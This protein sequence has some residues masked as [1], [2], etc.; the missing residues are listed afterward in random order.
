MMGDGF[1]ADYYIIKTKQR[2]DQER[3][4]HGSIMK[5]CQRLKIMI[6]QF[7]HLRFKKEKE[8]IICVNIIYYI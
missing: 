3:A 5:V 6:N 4:M 7:M 1:T 8:E 2:E